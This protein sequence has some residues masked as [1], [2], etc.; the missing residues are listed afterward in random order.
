LRLE[1]KLAL[2]SAQGRLCSWRERE[3]ERE[4]G[5]ERELCTN[6]YTE[7]RSSA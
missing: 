3:R 6:F 7:K 1:L 5:I 2:L 4:R